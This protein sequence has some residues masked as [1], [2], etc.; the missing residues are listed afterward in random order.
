MSGVRGLLKR[1]AERSLVA[2]GGWRVLRIVG[3]ADAVVLAY[4]NVVPDGASFGGDRSLHLDRADFARQLDLLAESHEVVAL[5]TLVGADDGKGGPPRAAVTFDDGYRGALTVGLEELEARGM[6]CTVFVPPALLGADRTW[7]DALATGDGLPEELRDEALTRAKG[8]AD[9]VWR[10]AEGR[11][12]DPGPQPGHAGL[13]DPDELA[14]AAAGDGV[15]VGSHGWSH[16]NLACLD[17]GE[18]DEELRRPLEWLEE[19]FPGS[20]VRWLSLP[21]G[22]GGER[23]VAAALEAGYRG[24][25]DLSGEMVDGE[26]LRAAR[27]IPRRNIPA[28]MT[29]EGFRLRALG[30]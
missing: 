8:R 14:E 25:L 22:L 16:A 10:W 11:G 15:T 28:G 30:L 6:P 24:V 1:L 26:A 23:V 9:D 27:R 19:R 5:E 2:L 13:V 20:L 29:A 17:G 18:L 21:Y 3:S 12:L 4:H 7:W